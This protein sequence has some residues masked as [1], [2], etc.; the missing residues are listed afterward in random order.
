MLVFHGAFVCLHRT[1]WGC[2]TFHDSS[3]C[4]C[5][6]P[7]KESGR[8]G[9]QTSLCSSLIVPSTSSLAWLVWRWGERRAGKGTVS[10]RCS[11][12][13]RPLSGHTGRKQ[14]L[15]SALCQHE[16]ALRALHHVGLVWGV[17]MHGVSLTVR[18][19]SR[20]RGGGGW[21][22]KWS[23]E[24]SP[25][26]VPSVEQ[27][28]EPVGEYLHG[29]QFKPALGRSVPH[30]A[31]AAQACELSCLCAPPCP[32]SVGCPCGEEITGCNG[33]V[34]LTAQQRPLVAHLGN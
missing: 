15:P 8:P 24:L 17:R 30:T 21:S 12:L 1:S 13:L 9:Q 23:Y 33:H 3:S 18:G 27:S 19:L 7:S 31:Q 11:C 29:S 28:T 5:I 16:A 10:I 32:A 25:H 14:I 4:R 2:T 22:G 34:L 6:T 26:P 20:C